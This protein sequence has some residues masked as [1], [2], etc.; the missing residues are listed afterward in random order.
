MKSI[1]VHEAVGTILSHDVTQIIPESVKGPAFRKGHIIREEDISKLLDIGKQNIYVFGMSPGM[2][3]E[4]EAAERI[5]NAAAGK[6]FHFSEVKEGRVNLVSEY[7]GLLKLNKEALF[8]LNSMDGIVFGT[9][10]NNQQV[11]AGQAVA[12]TRIIPLVIDDREIVAVENIC[13]SNYPLIEIKPYNAWRVGLITTGSEVYSGRIKDK[14]GPIVKKKFKALG[15]HVTRQVFVPDDVKMTVDNIH[16]FIN[17][18]AEMVILTGGMSVDPDD[19]TPTSIRAAGG[20][21]ITYGAPAFPGAM[22]ML[23]YINDVP[24]IGLPGCV[25]Y[26]RASIF[27]LVVPRLLAG[28]SVTKADIVSLGYG[29]FCAGCKVCKYPLCGFGKC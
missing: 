13:Q 25:M 16:R 23:A 28:E 20:K 3:H 15:S 18:G 22:F 4:N 10:H 21:V 8:Q 19:L 11:E 5:A 2:V 26:Y 12:G 14:F 6:G 29:S 9:M 27:E 17:E 1:P 7:P 24:I